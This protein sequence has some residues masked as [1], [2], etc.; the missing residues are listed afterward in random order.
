MNIKFLQEN[1]FQPEEQFSKSFFKCPDLTDFV[2][3][4]GTTHEFH[5]WHFWQVPLRCNF[6]L[7]QLHNGDQSM[8]S[9]DFIASGMSAQ[10]S[11]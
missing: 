4:Q 8:Q 1:L 9:L 5:D 3:T 2:T 7:I 6:P 11:L 10:H